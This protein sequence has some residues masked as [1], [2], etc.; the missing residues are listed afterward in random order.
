MPFHRF[1]E[2]KYERIRK[3]Y[4]LNELRSAEDDEVRRA[5]DLLRD[6][7][8]ERVFCERLPDI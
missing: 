5:V 3:D 1:G 8:A 4:A 6:A 7:G 2:G